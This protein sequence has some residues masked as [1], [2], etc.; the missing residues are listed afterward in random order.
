MVEFLKKNLILNLQMSN[1]DVVIQGHNAQN[2]E[3]TRDV[4]DRDIENGDVMIKIQSYSWGRNEQG[5]E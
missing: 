5:T 4:P 3:H 1:R 2:S